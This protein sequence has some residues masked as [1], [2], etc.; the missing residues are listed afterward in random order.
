[1]KTVDS[2][3]DADLMVL[4]EK[5]A[6]FYGHL[7]PFLVIGV[8]MGMIAKKALYI[9]PKQ[10]TKLRANA[11]IP[12][13]P[14]FSCILDGIQATTTCTV[15]NQRLIVENSEEMRVTFSRRDSNRMVKITL[16]PRLAE[17]LKEKLS[18]NALTEEFALK[19]AGL[20]ENQVFKI[21]LEH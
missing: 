10:Q 5:G 6:D 15:G 13:H 12:L 20:P 11:K 3:A 9:G 19:I 18:E 14:P 2:K 1:M 16:E 17:E 21:A 4:I 8:R 7:G